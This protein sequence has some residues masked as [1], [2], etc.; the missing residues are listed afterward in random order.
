MK[1]VRGLIRIADFLVRNEWRFLYADDLADE[2]SR[3]YCINRDY[4]RLIVEAFWSLRE[5]FPNKPR[6]WY[7]R[8]IVRLLNGVKRVKGDVWILKGIPELGDHYPVY[9]VWFAK[10]RYYC[11]CYSRKFGYRRRKSICTHVAA[12]ILSRKISRKI[13]EYL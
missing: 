10:G 1:D 12:V 13:G 4:V 8:A 3:R 7:V 11:S 2:V 5:S 9:Q 6:S